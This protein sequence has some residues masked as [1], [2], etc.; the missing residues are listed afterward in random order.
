MHP[1]LLAI[2]DELES[3]A[4]SRTKCRNKHSPGGLQSL[5]AT[6]VTPGTQIQSMT[7]EQPQPHIYL[8]SSLLLRSWQEPASKESANTP[9]AEASI[10][11]HREAESKGC[12]LKTPSG[13]GF[14]PIKLTE[15]QPVCRITEVLHVCK[16]HCCLESTALRVFTPCSGKGLPAPQPPHT[17]VEAGSKRRHNASEVL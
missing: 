4:P 10:P 12:V 16:A 2:W 14:P 15:V 17:Q 1:Q 11:P 6:A 7:L 3:L 5:P 8:S 13:G 9:T